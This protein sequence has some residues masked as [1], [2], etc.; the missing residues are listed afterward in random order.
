MSIDLTKKSY[1][2][3]WK[4]KSFLV[5]NVKIITFYIGGVRPND[6]SITLGGGVCPNDYNIT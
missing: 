6:Y 1:F 4:K 5:G 3:S 2:F